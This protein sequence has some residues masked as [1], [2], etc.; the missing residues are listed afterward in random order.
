MTELA[1]CKSSESVLDSQK[2]GKNVKLTSSVVKTGSTG[3][4]EKYI[5]IGVVDILD[6]FRTTLTIY[7]KI[8]VAFLAAAAQY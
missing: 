1:S 6:V 2:K 4:K 3:S 8:G 7:V 5:F